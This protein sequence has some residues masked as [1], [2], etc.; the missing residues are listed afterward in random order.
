MRRWEEMTAGER[1][2]MLRT[3]KHLSQNE[4]GQK[5][6]IA[7]RTISLWENG[8][9]NPNLVC[10]GMLAEFYGVST[11]FIVFGKNKG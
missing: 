5:L 3:E 11:D 7:R 4:V 8:Q 6:G 9:S 2:K 1:L 10:L